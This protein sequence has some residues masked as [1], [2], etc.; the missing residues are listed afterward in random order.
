MIGQF[1]IRTYEIFA[2]NKYSATH[3]LHAADVLNVR[4]LKLGF[5]MDKILFFT[6]VG[7]FSAFITAVIGFTKL[8]NDKESKVSEFRQEWTNTIRHTLAELVSCFRV[9]FELAEKSCQRAALCETVS[10]ELSSMKHDS[11]EYKIKNEALLHNKVM[12]EK[13]GEEI[14]ETKR[15]IHKN[16][17]LTLLHFK[18]NDSDFL[19]IEGKINAI[20]S[21]ISDFKNKSDKEDKDERLKKIISKGNEAETLCRDIL[22]LSRHVMKYEWERI[23]GGE[24]NYKKTKKI[25]KNGSLM[26]SLAMAIL[27]LLLTI[28]R[29][30]HYLAEEM[31]NKPASQTYSITSE[32][33]SSNEGLEK[34]N[35]WNSIE[36][37]ISPSD[38]KIEDAAAEQ[39]K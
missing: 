3:N 21:I 10:T 30:S 26:I 35:K 4:K 13:F 39:K 33:S 9:F 1:V 37:S 28:S 29:Y 15:N 16:V 5:P 19:H 34:S 12:L 36:D 14:I 8:I 11:V 17:A 31:S 6:I 22:S 24:E 38:K 27:F 7:L 25:F 18:P 20:L 23:K 32:S 2:A